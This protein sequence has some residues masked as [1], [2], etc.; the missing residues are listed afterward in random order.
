MKTFVYTGKHFILPTSL[1]GCFIQ[2]PFDMCF[3]MVYGSPSD[4]LVRVQ[5]RQMVDHETS[6]LEQGH[7]CCCSE[8]PARAVSLSLAKCLQASM[9][10]RDDKKIHIYTSAYLRMLAAICEG[11]VLVIGEIWVSLQSLMAAPT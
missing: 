5:L 11:M 4:P 6:D 3:S 10:L 7:P 2:W 8:D 1:E 9:K